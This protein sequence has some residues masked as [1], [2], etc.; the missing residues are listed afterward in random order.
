MLLPAYFNYV[1][2]PPVLALMLFYTVFRGLFFADKLLMFV[3]TQVVPSSTF[4]LTLF[5]AFWATLVSSDPT[6]NTT[7]TDLYVITF[8]YLLQAYQ[9]NMAIY[10]ALPGAIRFIDP[11]WDGVDEGMPLYPK[12]FY[13]LGFASREAEESQ[14][15]ESPI[16]TFDEDDLVDL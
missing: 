12:V 6:G 14:A 1:L 9:F 5:T 2:Y 7:N 10:E 15:D 8:F 13:W 16:I 4:W 3:F 11:S